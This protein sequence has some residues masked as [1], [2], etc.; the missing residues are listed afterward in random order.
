[1]LLSKACVYAIRA[2]LLV[3]SRDDPRERKF[4]PVREIAE[5][6]GLSFHFLTKVLQSLT[7]VGIMESFRGPRG[8][9]GLARP[10]GKI[11]LYDIVA[12]VD[13][14][15]AFESCVLGLPKCS[16]KAPCPM[17]T[18]WAKTRSRLVRMFERQTVASLSRNLTEFHLK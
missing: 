1:M 9:V 15:E 14:R 13:G 3:A 8:G 2:A 6:L 4:I 5:D 11:T 16:G 18:E 17:H 10:A 7:E 12:A